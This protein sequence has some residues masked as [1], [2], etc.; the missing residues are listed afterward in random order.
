V[1]V[2][3]P[4]IKSVRRDQASSFPESIFERWLFRNGL[5]TCVDHLVADPRI[6]G[7]KGYQAPFE[8]IKLFR[9]GIG[10]DWQWLRW[11]GIVIGFIEFIKDF[12]IEPLRNMSAFYG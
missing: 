11:G 7:P 1:L 10:N 8:I 12:H 2:F 9:L 6:F 4:F 3:F 5:E